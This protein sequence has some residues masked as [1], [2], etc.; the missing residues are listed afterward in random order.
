V[1]CW[2]PFA[3]SV[4]HNVFGAMLTPVLALSMLMLG[5]QY[6]CCGDV[7]DLL[8]LAFSA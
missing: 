6:A 5:R 4:L 1:S 8:L 3:T 2:L 7:S